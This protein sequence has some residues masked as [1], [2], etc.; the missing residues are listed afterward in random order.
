M[1][2]V[3]W[4]WDTG[5]YVPFCPYCNK[6]AYEKDHCVFC[7]KEYEW[8]GESKERIVTVGKYTVRQASSNHI[9]IVRDG[10][11]VFHAPWTKR[12]SKRQLKKMVDLFTF[13]DDLPSDV[14]KEIKERAEQ[15]KAVLSEKED[16]P[17]LEY[18]M[19]ASDDSKRGVFVIDKEEVATDERN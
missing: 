13:L 15:A 19:I 2:K 14:K 7:K 8:E 3:K 9:T 4:Y 10:I 16:V 5:C 1:K 18:E 17:P 12:K 11:R 6:L